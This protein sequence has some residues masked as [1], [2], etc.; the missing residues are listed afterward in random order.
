MAEKLIY[1]GNDQSIVDELN[2]STLFETEVSPDPF[3]A[4]K[5]IS[6]KGLIYAVI[7][8]EST[9]GISSKDFHKQVFSTLYF[10]GIPFIIFQSSTPSKDQIEDAL[11]KKIDDI[12]PKPV[13]IE[14]IDKRLNFLRK[15]KTNKLSFNKFKSKK[16]QLKIPFAKRIFDIVFALFALL[17]LSPIFLLVIILL[18][19]ESKGPFFYSS[20]RV[21]MGYEIFDFYKFRSMYVDA[22]KRLKDLAHLNQYNKEDIPIISEKSP[23]KTYADNGE[24]MLISDNEM[25]SESDYILKQRNK[26]EK[27][28]I[29][30]QNDPRITKVGR[31]IRKTS[32]DE[33]PQLV[34]V[35]K[36]DMSIV[37]NRP[38]PLYEAEVL[39]SDQYSERFLAPA[40]ITG[41]WQVTK[42]GK[43][44]MSN[45]ERKQ[46]D[47]T[48]ARTY[49]FWGDIV[50]LIRTAKAL[51][52][53]EDV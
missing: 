18:K 14:N 27:A 21:G 11:F 39:T 48:Y 40:G 24:T 1:I 19:L 44:D 13:S 45:E 29:K 2:K 12:Y 34:N 28:F 4:Q 35:L 46:L 26:K 41:L 22:D 30:I 10:R 9:K 6:K 32:I 16:H 8:D 37:G 42:R 3:L 23:E 25:I 50:L 17:M 53:T 36:G 33:L 47:N 49:T 7:F 15:Y 43:S 52:Q 51:L 31:F 5:L 20:K 38:I